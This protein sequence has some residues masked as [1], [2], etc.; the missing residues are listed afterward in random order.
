MTSAPLRQSG[1]KA[2][3]EALTGGY[4]I[5]AIETWEEDQTLASLS[6]FCQSVFQNRGVFQTWD[7]QNG[8][9]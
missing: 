2:M 4:P 5:I 1:I 6:S 3:R 9:T 8:L 7:L